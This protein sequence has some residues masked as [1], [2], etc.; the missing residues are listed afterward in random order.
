MKRVYYDVVEKY[1]SLNRDIENYCSNDVE[2][3]YKNSKNYC[4]DFD[5]GF[6]CFVNFNDV[7]LANC[8][9]ITRAGVFGKCK[10]AID[11]FKKNEPNAEIYAQVEA[12]NIKTP[13]L[14]SALG[15][16]QIYKT[17]FY[18]QILFLKI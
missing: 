8:G 6:V 17:I 18:L 13:P 12:G 1:M 3:D 2:I 10:D 15:F 11:E 5:L 4:Y 9:F 16:K 14:I 7:Y